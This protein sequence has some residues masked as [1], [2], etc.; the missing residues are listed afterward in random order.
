MT[1]VEI[2]SK[3]DH[4]NRNNRD[5]ILIIGVIKARMKI[6]FPSIICL[7]I[8]FMSL[9][10]CRNKNTIDQDST[11]VYSNLTDTYDSQTDSFTRNYD[12][13]KTTVKLHLTKEEKGKILEAFSENGF[14]N[15]PGTIDCTTWGY[16]PKIYDRLSLNTINVE[17]IHNVD[18]SWFCYNGKKFDKI[19]TIIEN[20]IFTKNEIKQL[21]PS[22][23][24]YE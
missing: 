24:A 10:S 11:F 13:H 22:S 8:V 7:L 6:Y 23:I 19:Y 2:F 21:E 17:Y 15:L 18:R 5:K 4:Q 12:S 14:Q 16:H 20:I 9:T 3:I 1:K